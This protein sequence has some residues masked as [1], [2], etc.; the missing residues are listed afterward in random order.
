MITSTDRT[1]RN[2][3]A[4]L[5][6]MPTRNV[7]RTLEGASSL[8][9]G[10]FEVGGALDSI[11][12]I[13]R[14]TLNLVVIKVYSFL[15]D[16]NTLGTLTDRQIDRILFE[17]SNGAKAGTYS[18]FGGMNDPNAALISS[19]VAKVT[20]FT[21]ETVYDVLFALKSLVD[22]GDTEASTILN[23]TGIGF[24]D[25]LVNTGPVGALAKLAHNALDDLFAGFGIP[26]EAVTLLLY[27][28]LAFGVIYVVK[29]GKAMFK[30]VTSK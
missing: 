26:K 3:L 10:I 29:N 23:G 7:L 4:V 12:N 28:G 11:F 27:T 6:G 18:V 19:G 9:S 20:G 2:V 22:G 15:W 24:A 8:A 13:V 25:Q 5:E 14:T 17:Y 16:H 21:Q 30:E 1:P